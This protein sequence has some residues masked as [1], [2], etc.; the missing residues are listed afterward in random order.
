MRELRTE[1]V[2][3]TRGVFSL[4][5]LTVERKEKRQAVVEDKKRKRLWYF[6]CSGLESGS[7]SQ[8][9][10]AFVAEMLFI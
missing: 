5:R 6:I 10:G 7:A 2:M 8:V 9:Q 3:G 1:R 4:Q